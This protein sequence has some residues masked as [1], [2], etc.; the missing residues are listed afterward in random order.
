MMVQLMCM[1][2]MLENKLY[3]EY[4]IKQATNGDVGDFWWRLARVSLRRLAPVHFECIIKQ[5]GLAR[6][7]G[8]L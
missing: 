2:G 8:L 7:R 6:T 4:D 5:L 3:S 1:I